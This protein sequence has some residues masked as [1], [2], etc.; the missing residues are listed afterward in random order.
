LDV[1]QD[2]WERGFQL[3][4]FLFPERS[5]ALRVLTGALNKL[6]VQRGRETRRSYWRDKHL[7]RGITR[8]TRDEGDALQWL[9]FSESDA[10]EKEREQEQAPTSAEMAV[11]YIRNLVRMTT[12]MSSF[13]VNVGLHRLLF[14]YSTVEAQ[15][16]YESVTE[17]FLGADEYRRAKGALMKKL[18]KRFTTLKTCRTQHGELRFETLTYETDAQHATLTS[19]VDSCLRAFTPWSTLQACPVPANYDASRDRLPSDLSGQGRGKVDF[20]RVEINRCHAFIDP[21]CDS[22]LME[23]LLLQPP[24]EKLALPRFYMENE[25]HDNNPAQTGGTTGLTPSERA[26]IS[27]DLADR[28]GRRKSTDPQAMIVVV[29]GEQKAQLTL[30]AESMLTFALEEGDQL[31]E[32]RELGADGDQLLALHALAYT[33]SRGI[34]ET[35]VRLWQGN[36]GTLALAITPDSQTGE[37]PL[38]ATATLR[39]KPRV[40]PFPWA[41]RVFTRNGKMLFPRLAFAALALALAAGITLRLIKTHENATSLTTLKPGTESPTQPAIPQGTPAIAAAT[42]NPEASATPMPEVASLHV[43]YT[44]VPEELKVRGPNGSETLLAI[45]QKSAV[46]DLQLPIEADYAGETFHASLKLFFAPGDIVSMNGLHA[47]KSRKGLIVTFAVPSGKLKAGEEYVVELQTG[48]KN[49][50]METVESYGFR[51]KQGR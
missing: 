3:A 25:R 6:R 9:I 12:S 17:R 26:T 39:F 24:M 19:L 23:A 29:D 22:R 48:K 44:L 49:Q 42:P 38:K 20:N 28:A 41:S 43:R 40:F 46:I 15:R 27:K 34:A 37:E 36:A 8:I 11:R 45:P 4:Y 31:I 7:K 16:V 33:E 10:V 21:V 30:T 5:T 18:G 1:D 51:T 32:L 50:K 47:E 2:L 35:H 13:Y 14:N